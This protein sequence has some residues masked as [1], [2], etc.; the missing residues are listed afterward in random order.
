MAGFSSSNEQ[1]SQSCPSC[2]AAVGA[3]A[4]QQQDARDSAAVSARMRCA[5]MLLAAAASLC[6]HARLQRLAELRPHPPDL[7]LC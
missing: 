6:R 2:S 5:D 3:T 1:Q 4:R 7:L